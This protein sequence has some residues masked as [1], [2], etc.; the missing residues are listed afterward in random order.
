MVFDGT[1]SISYLGGPATKV[2]VGT[3]DDVD[4]TK[5]NILN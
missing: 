5:S 3:I 1:A 4:G 2:C